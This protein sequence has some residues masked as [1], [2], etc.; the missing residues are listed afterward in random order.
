MFWKL[1]LAIQLN[2]AVD[3]LLSLSIANGWVRPSFTIKRFFK[4]ELNNL[5][6]TQLLKAL[7]E[8][9]KLYQAQVIADKLGRFLTKAE[10][11]IIQE[12]NIDKGNFEEVN[13]TATFI[14]KP[15]NPAQRQRL[16]SAC[17]YKG[18]TFSAYQLN[19]QV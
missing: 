8:K 6:L 17:A 14:G 3:W 10:L 12:V 9:G 5:E 7:I 11:A 19:L 16:T 2:I 15:L 13:L 4:E 1:Y 18:D